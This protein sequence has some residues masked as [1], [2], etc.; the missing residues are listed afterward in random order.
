M[1]RLDVRASVR[2]LQGRGDGKIVSRS[3]E[4]RWLMDFLRAHHDGKL[5]GAS[6]LR[7]ESNPE[8]R[9]WYYGIDGEALRIYRQDILG[10]GRQKVLVLSGSGNIDV[11]LRIFSSPR[12]EPWIITSRGGKEISGRNSRG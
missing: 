1:L 4:D 5:I 7:D 6:T 10:L 11:T 8:G 12:V 9:G 3:S 2:E